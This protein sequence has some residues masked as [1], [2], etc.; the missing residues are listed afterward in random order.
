MSKKEEVATEFNEFFT[1][2]IKKLRD[3]TENKQKTDP[4]RG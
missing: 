2:K 4:E 3:K 1:D